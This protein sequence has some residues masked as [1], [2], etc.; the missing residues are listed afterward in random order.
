ML[1]W[2]KNPDEDR[3]VKISLKELQLPGWTYLNWTK[4]GHPYDTVDVI[5]KYSLSNCNLGCASPGMS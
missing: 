3:N 4:L 2:L 1:S 5:W